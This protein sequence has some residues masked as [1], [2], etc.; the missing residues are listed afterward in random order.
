M[1]SLAGSAIA[2]LTSTSCSSPQPKPSSNVERSSRASAPQPTYRTAPI[3]NSTPISQQERAA[4][5]EIQLLYQR[6]SYLEVTQKAQAFEI[7]FPRSSRLPEALNLKGLALL[8]AGNAEEAASVFRLA[9]ERAPDALAGDRHWRNYVRYN[10]AAA[11][12]ESGAAQVAINELAGIEPESYDPPNRIKFYQV[13]ARAHELLGNAIEAAAEW[14][15]LAKMESS[16]ELSRVPIESNFSAL[17]SRVRDRSTLEQISGAAEKTSL[18]ATAKFYWIRKEIEE[19]RISDAHA[20]AKAFLSEY[21]LSSKAREISDL[22]R[23]KKENGETAELS[24]GLLVPQTGK[25]SRVGQRVIQSVSLALGIFENGAAASR[26]RLIIEDSGDDA[27]EALSALERLHQKHRV[28]AVIGPVLSKGADLVISRAEH[29]GLP[30]VSLAQQ[31]GSFGSFS[32]QGA[33]TPR[34]QATEIAR[35]AIQGLGLKRFAILA[36]RD[37]FGEEF[38]QEFWTAV[39]TLGGSITAYENYSP[40]ETDFRESMDRL[41]GTYYSEARRRELAELAKEREANQIKKRT[42]RT[43]KFFALPPIVSFEAVFIPDEPKAVGLALPTFTYR[44][45]DGVKFLG[46]SSWNSPELTQRAQK[47]AEGAFF[48]DSYFALSQSPLTRKFADR[49]RTDFG[50][51]A[52]SLEAV[53]FDVGTLIE[54]VLSQEAT[55]TGVDRNRVAARIRQI[56]DTPAVTGKITVQDG[57]WTRDLKVLTI[58]DEQVVEANRERP[59]RAAD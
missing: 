25:Y 50:Q 41:A 30:L 23:L 29:Y 34:L 15:A 52:G 45:I 44:D 43:E 27:E 56:R 1:R 33:V 51:E 2:L 37:R 18:A 21:P 16:P 13:R 3:L 47:S 46:I 36:P 24:L 40:G 6:G 28:A 54:K 49:F 32:S 31:A 20:H 7:R 35:H 4:L 38:S 59:A 39:E 9:V 14:I 42:R 17:L 48:V 12:L 53:A 8:L 10:L 5:A 11:L 26:I 57:F 55:P 22:L 19:N 58:R